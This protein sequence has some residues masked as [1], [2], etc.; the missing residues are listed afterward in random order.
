MIII[1]LSF[2]IIIPIIYCVKD[3][4][5]RKKL[6]TLTGKVYY[7]KK[8]NGFIVKVQYKDINNNKAFRNARDEDI[9]ILKKYKKFS[10]INCDI[11]NIKSLSKIFNAQERTRTFTPLRTRPSTVR[12]YQFRHL[13][14]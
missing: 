13:G 8:P 5:M 7:V 4:Y 12:V 6:G 3:Y 1:F 9:V 14:K 10:F 11:E 2:F